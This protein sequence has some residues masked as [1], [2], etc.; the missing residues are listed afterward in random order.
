MTDHDDL[1][2]CELDFGADPVSDDDLDYVILSPDG[3]PKKLAEY[4]ALFGPEG[5]EHAE[6]AVDR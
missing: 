6:G 4:L 2:G 5:G 3:D 1:D